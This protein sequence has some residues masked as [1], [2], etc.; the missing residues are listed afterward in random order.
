MQKTCTRKSPLKLRIKFWQLRYFFCENWSKK[1]LSVQ[2]WKTKLEKNCSSLKRCFG[3]VKCS[4]NIPVEKLDKKPKTSC[5]LSKNDE[6]FHLFSETVFSP[7]WFYRYKECCFDR[8]AK[9]FLAQLLEMIRKKVHKRCKSFSK[10]ISPNCSHG[11]VES[12]LKAPLTFFGQPAEIFLLEIQEKNNL[13]FCKRLAPE[14]LHWNW[15]SSFD[16]SATFYSENWSKK[17]LSVQKWK[18]KLEKK[19]FFVKMLFWTRKM[20]F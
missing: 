8:P 15:E 17:S 18:K 4:S 9:I 16:N 3:H 11:E 10:R 5:S 19:Q 2:K 20:Q 7:K 6:N 1:S 12:S 13:R 14:S